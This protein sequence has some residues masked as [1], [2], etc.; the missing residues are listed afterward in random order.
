[1]RV[2][3]ATCAAL[4]DLDADDL[5][6]LHALTARG[7]AARPVVWD[8]PDVD[9]SREDAVVIRSTWDYA[10]QRDHFVAWAREVAGAVPLFNGADVVAAN[11]DKTYLR[12]LAAQG[13][14]TVETRWLTRG[15]AVDLAAVL[16]DAGWTAAVVKP[17][18]S[19]GGRETLRIGTGDTVAGQALVDRL[20]AAGDA[21]VQRYLPGVEHDGELSIVFVGGVATHA[22]RKRP[23]A[24]DFRVQERFGGSWTGADATADEL[25][26]AR[27]ALTACADDVLY[28]R[29][30][31][32]PAPD[33]PRV[34]E[35]ELVE[36]SL[37][38][39]A[40]PHAAG[41]LA[42]ALLARLG[43]PARASA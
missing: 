11:T 4:P 18:V 3:L 2:A 8:D 36:P 38:L 35:V 24:G 32:L 9:W 43:R 23:A 39:T 33:G 20:L 17:T 12:D 10:T 30:D 14:P 28:A 25:A 27:A 29:V 15:D 13:T 1:M 34:V 40:V 16:A 19:A 7:V 41:R 21:M 22:V 37:Y 42:D 6:L 31:L 26:V 5:P